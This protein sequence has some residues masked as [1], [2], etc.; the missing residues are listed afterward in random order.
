MVI[1]DLLKDNSQ[2]YTNEI[3]ITEIYFSNRIFQQEKAS[4]RFN[5][6]KCKRSITWKN[7]D[8]LAN[9][10]ANFLLGLGVKK[11]DKIS[12]LLPNCLE[13]LPLFFGI[14][15]TGAIAV[16]LNFRY[17][18]EELFHCLNTSDCSVVFSSIEFDKKIKKAINNL[19]NKPKLIYIGD[20]DSSNEECFY[21]LINNISDAAPL[22]VINEQDY[23][24]IYFSSGTTGLPKAILHT[25]KA[26]MAAAESEVVH[27]FQRHNDNF[28]CMP[29]LYH[30]GSKMHWF[31][32]LMVGG[33]MVLLLDISPRYIM[34]TISE[35]RI[36]IVWLIVPWAQ[37]IL[38]SIDCGDILLEQYNIEQ[39]RLTH[40]GA[41]PIPA[42]LIHQWQKKFPNQ[43]YDTNY[44]L[45]ETAGPGC[46]HLGTLNMHKI[47]SI[48]KAGYGWNVKIVDKNGDSVQ[49]GEIGELAV[50]GPGVMVEYYK[51]P[52]ATKEVL[53][54]GWLLTGDIAYADDDG[55]IFLVD[56][57]KD[58]II[59]GGENIYPVQIE[60]FLIQ[61]KAIKDVAV[62]GLNDP[63][64][65]EMVTAIVEVK[66][67]IKCSKLEILK[68]CQS[69]PSYKR[70]RRIIFAS[71]P[72]NATGKI[73]KNVLRKIYQNN[74]CHG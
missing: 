25:H 71:I 57:K 30:T 58:I 38:N 2:K 6:E 11:N 24:A 34:E 7:F 65:G 36:T 31:G 20:N 28:L 47:G 29:P 8:I 72:R 56:R 22:E 13:W 68:F 60:Q 9:K 21:K 3:A 46:I 53:K 48:G 23:A 73:E 19:I 16:P 67:G 41:Q 42:T 55:F 59:S 70:P 74:E 4:S 37:D 27:H 66:S 1:T 43:L 50:R 52:T 18:S 15:R 26:L 54:D 63:R 17:D 12:I 33:S 10:T 40:M 5:K 64:L 61:H 32:S 62:I 51:N 69:L 45:S 35:E 44:G 14:L 39:W 49:P